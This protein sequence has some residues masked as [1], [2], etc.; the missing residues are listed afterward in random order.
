MP[1]AKL[2]LSTGTCPEPAKNNSSFLAAMGLNTNDSYRLEAQGLFTESPPSSPPD[3]LFK[4][5]FLAK[6][7]WESSLS[8]FLFTV[9]LIASNP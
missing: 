6:A 1:E 8:N 4:I 9:I 7:P 2:L 5:L 3:K